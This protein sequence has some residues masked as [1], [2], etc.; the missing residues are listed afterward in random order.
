MFDVRLWSVEYGTLLMGEFLVELFELIACLEE[1]AIEIPMGRSNYA[2][3]PQNIADFVRIM[4]RERCVSKIHA[5]CFIVGA[6]PDQDPD[7]AV[8][9]FETFMLQWTFP[10]G[11]RVIYGAGNG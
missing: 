4:N 10:P 8:A 1:L 9:E 7:D 2:H 6:R 5:L 11:L 3:T